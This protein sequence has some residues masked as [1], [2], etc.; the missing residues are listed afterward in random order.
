M[1]NLGRGTKPPSILRSESL[2]SYAGSFP[3]T[4]RRSPQGPRA[5]DGRR[6]AMGLPRSHV[7]CGRW[8]ADTRG[9]MSQVRNARRDRVRLAVTPIFGYAFADGIDARPRAGVRVANEST[10]AVTVSEIGWL[11]I[12]QSRLVI[13]IPVFFKEDVA[14][15]VRLESGASFDGYADIGVEASPAFQHVTKAYATNGYART[16]FGH[17]CRPKAGC[18]RVCDSRTSTSGVR[19]LQSGH[20]ELGSV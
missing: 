1:T 5:N 2:C 6:L 11:T 17:V 18:A 14:M 7:R 16:L 3:S 8:W 15:P 4:R 20:H 9:I 12:G 13:G 10:F 19:T